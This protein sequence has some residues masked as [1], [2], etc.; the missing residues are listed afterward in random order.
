MRV[1]V[2][3]FLLRTVLVGAL[4]TAAYK[5]FTLQ[6]SGDKEFHPQDDDAKPGG[7]DGGAGPA[8]ARRDGLGGQGDHRAGT[9][10]LTGGPAGGRNSLRDTTVYPGASKTRM[11]GIL[12][13]KPDGTPGYTPSPCPTNY[14]IAE[15]LRANGFFGRLSDCLPLD[16]NI[17]DGR[18]EMCAKVR[19]V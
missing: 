13:L 9:G 2:R 17:T 11:H 7:A 15:E 6:S 3:R 18:H 10:G 19:L 5:V 4:L 1:H 16:R 12:G 14:K 8:V